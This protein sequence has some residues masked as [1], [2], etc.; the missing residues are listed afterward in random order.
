MS[1]APSELLRRAEEILAKKGKTFHWAK[2]LLN[3][4]HGERATRLYAF[5]RYLDDL[6]DE[7]PSKEQARVQL[8]EVSRALLTGQT[9]DPVITDALQ[10]MTECRIEPRIPQEL[11]NGLLTDLEE[12][13]FKTVDELL[14]YCYRV[15]GTVGLMMSDVLDV[16]DPGASAFAID[17]GI[18]MQ[19]TN[20]CRDIQEDA[21][22]GRRYVPTEIIGKVTLEE[23]I[24]PTE[25]PQRRLRVGVGYLLNLADEYYRS[26]ESGLPFLP[27]RA[28][29]GILIAAKVYR[30]IG[31]KLRECD[32]N[33]WE[34]RAAISKARKAR[35]TLVALGGSFIGSRFWQKP[36]RHNAELHRALKGLPRVDSQYGI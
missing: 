7:A 6:A 5:C 8:T 14:R 16:A 3:P 13:E 25:V 4:K 34:E 28:R 36:L 31:V 12:V 33:Y 26:G 20:I 17:L 32:Y 2:R 1:V 29:H 15:A 10:L 18:G 35:I 21:R 24:Q 9:N 11:I 23:L 30:A 19:L 22:M 27:L